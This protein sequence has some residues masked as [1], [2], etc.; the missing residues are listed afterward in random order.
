M[1]R[2][3][4]NRKTINCKLRFD[5]PQLFCGYETY[6]LKKDLPEELGFDLRVFRKCD[7]RAPE[8]SC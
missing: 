3:I 4:T 5:S 1:K 8:K 2:F 6:M 7:A